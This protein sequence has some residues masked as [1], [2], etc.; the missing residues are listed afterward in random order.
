MKFEQ[1]FWNRENLSM[2]SNLRGFENALPVFLFVTGPTGQITGWDIIVGSALHTFISTT[3]LEDFPTA[4]DEGIIVGPH[5]G[6]FGF[7][8]DQPGV[9]ENRTAVTDSGSTLLVLTLTLMALG[10]AAQ[11]FKRAAA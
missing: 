11:Q 5:T 8:Q 10:V 3:N 7:N 1:A 2:R 4:N 9:W 6:S